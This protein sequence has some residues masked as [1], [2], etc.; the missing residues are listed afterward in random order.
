MDTDG[1]RYTGPRTTDYGTRG[2]QKAEAEVQASLRRQ[3]IPEADEAEAGEVRF[4]ACGEFVTG[5]DWCRTKSWRLSRRF[6]WPASASPH[7]RA[8][9]PRWRPSGNASR[10]WVG[11]GLGLRRSI[12]SA[13]AEEFGHGQVELRGQPLDLL[14][15]RIGQLH[16]GSFH[17]GS[18]LTLWHSCK[19]KFPHGLSW[20]RGK[21]VAGRGQRGKGFSESSPVA[22]SRVG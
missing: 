16:F 17:V 7:R 18:L 13:P 14:V 4:V 9:A 22:E 6:R 5:A 1:H 15:N 21:A 20:D 8:N 10:R 2:R 12:C 11:R 19:A 3:R